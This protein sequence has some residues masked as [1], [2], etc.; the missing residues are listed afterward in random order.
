MFRRLFVSVFIVASVVGTSG[1]TP[2]PD[3]ISLDDAKKGIR[4]LFYDYHQACEVSAE[5]CKSFYMEHQHPDVYDFSKPE[6]K[7]LL[8]EFDRS[9]DSYGTPDLS[10]VAPDP[11]WTYPPTQACDP[12]SIS[13]KTPPRGTTFIVT[14][15]GSDVHVTFLDKKFYFYQG[16]VNE[17]D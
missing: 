9:W 15:G 4:A 13:S 17:C 16:L 10:T 3:A 2:N 6:V 8:A 7:A 5:S 11:E 1:C 14:S 12:V